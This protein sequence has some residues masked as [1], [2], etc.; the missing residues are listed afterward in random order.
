MAVTRVSPMENPQRYFT[1]ALDSYDGG[2]LKGRINHKSKDGIY[3]FENTMEVV[4]FMEN[5]FSIIN[6]PMKTMDLRQFDFLRN[7]D[8]V[9]NSNYKMISTIN[10]EPIK[11]EL[12]TIQLNVNYRH[13][14]TWQGELHW[15]ER[16]ESQSFDSFLQLLQLIDDGLSY[17]SGK[18]AENILTMLS[19]A[20]MGRCRSGGKKAAFVIRV[21]FEKNSTWQGTIMLTETGQQ[22]NFRS[23]LE[24]ILLM[25]DTLSHY[26]MWQDSRKQNYI[27]QIV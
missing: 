6:F 2:R 15:V 3:A 22:V 9:K 12:A 16:G 25:N 26:G 13:H 24:L 7:E 1:L 21:L 10:R 17:K 14:A 5:I 23:F 8:D 27:K 11:G 18:A 20:A 19:E 4:L